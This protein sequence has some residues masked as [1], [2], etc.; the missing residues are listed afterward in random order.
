M[1]RENK[2]H[3]QEDLF[4]NLYTMDSRL[5]EKLKKS[6]AAFFYEH[7]F[8]KIDENLFA[9]L[10][11][12]DN[13]R[14]NF[15]VNILMGLDLIKEIRGYTDEVLFDEYAYNLQVSY[16][17]G[18]RTLGERYFAPRTLYEFRA[19]LYN[20]SLEHPEEADLIFAQF[21]KLTEHFIEVAKL[22][23]LEARM[24]STQIMFN[25]KL[26]GR[27]SLAYDVLVNGIKALPEKL[28]NDTLKLFL[29]SDYKTQFLYKLKGKDSSSRIQNLIEH[30]AE[31]LQLVQN[32]PEL[33]ANPA[34]KLTERF[35]TEQATF[36]KEQNRWIAKNNKD[37]SPKSLQSAY[38]TD[39]TYRKKNGKKHV[40]YVLNL[41]E[42]CGDENPVQMVTHYNLAPNTTSDVELLKKVLPELK[43]KGVK[44][45]YTDGAYYSSEIVEKSKTQGIE[46][47]Y[48][49]MTG[50]KKSNNK[51]PY[52]AFE[53]ENKEKI[54]RCPADQ[55]PIRTA[56]KKKN[57]ILS[58]HFNRNICEKCPLKENCRVKFQK[59]ST[60]IRVS[61]KTLL[62][63]EARLKFADKEKRQKATSKRA[64]IEG[65]NSSLKR[66]QGLGKLNVRGIVKS[67]LAVGAKIIAHNFR[68]LTRFFNGDIREKAKKPLKLNQGIPITI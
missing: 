13:G 1:F 43:N 8:C 62:T 42:T 30:C 36:N 52:N 55:E 32:Y 38:D 53:I 66:A 23:T 33:K 31:I 19:R 63:E 21:E 14:P 67:N 20:Y 41:T 57:K 17:L 29:K 4:N 56:F 2:D 37:I 27:L 64:A 7:I 60:V 18:L 68:Q 49:D 65:T 22:N 50:R 48:T 6:W 44:D 26:A 40:G 58:A 39:A 35:L 54:L 61:Q 11:C 25:I 45:L 9:P 12:N 15:P 5:V 3:L 24:D 16:A 51:F 59:K 34:I 46:I 10:Y 28:L 47:H